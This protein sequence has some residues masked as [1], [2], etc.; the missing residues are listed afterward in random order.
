MYDRSV[1]IFRRDLR[2]VD[3]TAL[4]AAA[5]ESKEVLLCFIFD[6]RQKNHDYFSSPGFQF[7]CES[8]KDLQNACA[9]AG[10]KLFIFSGLP[11][12]VLQDVHANA[13]IAAVYT[14]ADYTPFSKKRDAK[15]EAWCKENDI[16]WHQYD[17]ALLQ[18]GVLKDD[19]AP[20]TVFTPYYRKASQIEVRK[21]QGIP[22]C[23]WF[24]KILPI[25]S[26]I[27]LYEDLPDLHVHGGRGEALKI[28]GEISHLR[29]Y[30]SSRDT[31]R[32][33]TSGLSAHNKFG[34][35]SIR[36][37]YY[38]IR[39]A[40]GAFHPLLRQLYWRDFF[41]M[42]AIN[43][44]S[45]FGHA[46]Q[47]KFEGVKWDHDTKN[48]T[49]WCEG[50]TGFPIVD[51]GMR[52][53]NTTGYMHNRVRM[54]V[55]SFLTKDLHIDWRWGEKYFAQKLVDYD[56]CVNNGSWQWAASTGCDAQPYFRIF[57]PWLQQKK[58]DPDCE[59]IKKW[60]P[61]LRDIS[62]AEIHNEYAEIKGYVPP[63]VVHA[64]EKDIALQRFAITKSNNTDA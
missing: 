11:E 2:L 55:A 38:G 48:F 25:E 28:L 50:K 60:V 4:Y 6:P 1:F 58:F 37:V 10:S 16:A 34:T 44:P 41:H 45:V 30:E 26:Q 59:Y 54:I 15:I 53:L 62:I 22:S 51:A 56:P 43:F 20:Y 61:E 36:E 17:D 52:Q 57:N 29:D 35:V 21:P 42:I 13:P 39:K 23:T 9:E 14:N 31:P 27:P 63:I 8:L 40:L 46:F 5:Q 33:Q 24:A 3:N 64:A 47:K 7:L 19:G 18:P 32:L 49:M 12:D